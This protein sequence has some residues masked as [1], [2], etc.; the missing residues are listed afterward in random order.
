MK[1]L[2]WLK[3]YWYIPLA[4]LGALVG[5]LFWLATRDKGAHPMEGVLKE[6]DAIRAKREARE[7]VLALGEEKA[8]A[9]VLEKYAAKRQDLDAAGAARIQELENGDLETLAAALERATRG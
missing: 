3:D 2:R 5:L 4:I 6:L 7:A 1:A 9:Q 8:R